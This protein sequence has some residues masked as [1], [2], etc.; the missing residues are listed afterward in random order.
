MTV[1]FSVCLSVCLLEGLHK[2]YY[3]DLLNNIRMVLVKLRC[4]YICHLIDPGVLLCFTM[5]C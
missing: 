2:Y 4:Q 3:L 5:Y 1:S